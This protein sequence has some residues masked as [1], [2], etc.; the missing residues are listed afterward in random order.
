[1]TESDDMGDFNITDYQP[2]EST[3]RKNAKRR[4]GGVALYAQNGI[5]Y[6]QIQ[7]GTEIECRV[8][9]IKIGVQTKRKVSYR[10]K[11]YV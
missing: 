1:M 8:F 2:I 3:P 7:V 5:D 6:K 9:E 4:S 11:N 10:N